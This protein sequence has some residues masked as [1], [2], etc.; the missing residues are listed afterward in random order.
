MQGAYSLASRRGLLNDASNLLFTAGFW[1]Y[2]RE[3]IT[4][5]LF[6]GCTLKMDVSG[7]GPLNTG[8]PGHLHDMSLILGR[9]INATF[10]RPIAGE[11]WT[12]LAETT[13]AWY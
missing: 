11:E 6:E 4:F 5:S 13:A 7:V 3:D 9:L 8:Q 1:N 12:E 2:L 10:E